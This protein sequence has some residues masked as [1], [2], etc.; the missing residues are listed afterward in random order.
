[1]QDFLPKDVH[2]EILNGINIFRMNLCSADSGVTQVNSTGSVTTARN[3][4]LQYRYSGKWNRCWMGKVP[5]P[6]I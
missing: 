6:K 5:I 3:T 1:M 4:A 2:P